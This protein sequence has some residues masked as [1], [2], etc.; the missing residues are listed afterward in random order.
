MS[1]RLV[2]PTCDA[3]PFTIR[4][5]YDAHVATCSP[6]VRP[7]PEPEPP[8]PEP[9]LTAVADT[10]PDHVCETCGA[11]P[12]ATVKGYKA[13]IRAHNRVDCPECGQLCSGAGGLAKHRNHAHGVISETAA[14]KA[15]Q[16]QNGAAR[17]RAA[18]RAEPRRQHPD[19]APAL[20][21]LGFPPELVD[22]FATFVTRHQPDRDLWLVATA[23]TGPW[24]CRVGQ[25]GLLAQREHT[26]IVAVQV[27]D[28]C[29]LIDRAPATEGATS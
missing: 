14:R 2:C 18:V 11:G 26:P 9:S 15:T 28:I 5:V 6:V 10:P 12:F 24:L 27:A 7:V 23:D 20:H 16:R 29:T 25:L 21:Q 19:L 1:K 3:G 13:H 8:G 17:R 22:R 4:K